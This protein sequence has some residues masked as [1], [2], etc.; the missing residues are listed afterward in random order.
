M[1]ASTLSTRPGGAIT[2]TYVIV[3]GW[4]A[5]PF[6]LKWARLFGG[7]LMGWLARGARP[8][9]AALGLTNPLYVFTQRSTDPHA[10]ARDLILTMAVQGGLSLA[11]VAGSAAILRPLVR[12]A[13]PF[14]WRVATWSFLLSRRRL[15]PRPPCG[16]KPMVWK[17]CHDARTTIL[18][19]L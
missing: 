14:G 1:A 2:S 12:G 10:T 6:L 11:L 18:F 15:L 5:G 8:L 13:G 7:G 16:D 17:E 3:A 19:R 4:M 9:E